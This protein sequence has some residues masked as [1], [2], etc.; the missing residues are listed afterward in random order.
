MSRIE[1]GP[2]KT[3]LR[4]LRPIGLQMRRGGGGGSRGLDP[5]LV[6]DVG[7]LK[8]GAKAGPPPPLCVDLHV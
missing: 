2:K 7:F 8:F 1:R 4:A 5:L 6:H 3:L